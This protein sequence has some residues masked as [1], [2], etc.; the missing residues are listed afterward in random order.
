MMDSKGHLETLGS[1]SDCKVK[2][3][4]CKYSLILRYT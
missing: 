1:P 4:S 3:L 2:Q